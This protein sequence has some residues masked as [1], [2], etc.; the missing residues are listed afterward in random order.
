MRALGQQV[1]TARC[2]GDEAAAVRFAERFLELLSETD[3]ARGLIAE[4]EHAK[5]VL[6]RY[7][8][9]GGRWRAAAETML[10]ALAQG[11]GNGGALVLS[12]RESE[13]LA[14]LASQRDKEIA[15]GLGLT[16]S[17]VRYHVT[18]ILAKL[19]A[20]GRMDAVHRARGI[21]LLP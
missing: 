7:L 3:Y 14:R 9:A 15:A 17:G 11:R 19:G 16:P 13:I 21:G 20:R 5:W 18:N 12:S 8:D 1:G 4:G 2:A 6:T 10:A